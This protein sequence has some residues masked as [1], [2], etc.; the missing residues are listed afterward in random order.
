MKEIN[1]IS[2]EELELVE[3]ERTI[4]TKTRL[5]NEKKAVED[6]LAKFEE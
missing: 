6:M 2:D 3:T 4:I 5:L 1:K